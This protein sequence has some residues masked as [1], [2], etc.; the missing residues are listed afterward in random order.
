MKLDDEI[1]FEIGL[2]Q[3]AMTPRLQALILEG[4]DYRLTGSKGCGKWDLVRKFKCSVTLRQLR[5]GAVG[6]GADR[7]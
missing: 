6:G 1:E 5:R 7:G 4:A 2:Y 3:D